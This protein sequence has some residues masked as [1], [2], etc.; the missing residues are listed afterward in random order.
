MQ[1]ESLLFSL[2][3]LIFSF[4]LLTKRLWGAFFV[5]DIFPTLETHCLRCAWV[6]FILQ[7]ESLTF[8]ML[9]NY[10]LVRH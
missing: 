5:C 2:C 7:L 10:P 4:C 9:V 1:S 6:D 3:S 8:F